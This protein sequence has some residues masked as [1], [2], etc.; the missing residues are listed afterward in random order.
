[1][2]KRFIIPSGLYKEGGGKHDCLD[3]VYTL[4]L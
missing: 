2:G 4:I 3:K 1:M